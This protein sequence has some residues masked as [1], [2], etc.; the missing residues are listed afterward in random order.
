M[1]QNDLNKNAST[2]YL[3]VL[4]FINLTENPNQIFALTL[5]SGSLWR[6][7][8]SSKIKRISGNCIENLL[9]ASKQKV[10]RIQNAQIF[11]S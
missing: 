1:N 2:I 9:G 6:G 5:S 3:F 7:N 8:R 10:T 4:L 11:A